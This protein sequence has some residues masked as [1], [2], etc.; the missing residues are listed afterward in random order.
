MMVLSMQFFVKWGNIVCHWDKIFVSSSTEAQG[1]TGWWGNTLFKMHHYWSN[2]FY[3]KCYIN[4]V[5]IL[6][7]KM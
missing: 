6:V 2:Y 7:D 5:A 4:I 3:Q 1:G